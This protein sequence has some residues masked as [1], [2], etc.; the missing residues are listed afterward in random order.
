MEKCI[1]KAFEDGGSVIKKPKIIND[2]SKKTGTTVHFKPDSSIFS[3]TI[4]DYK[5]CAQ[6]LKESAFLIKGLKVTLV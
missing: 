2:N 4:F 3:T 6:R 1:H 5:Q